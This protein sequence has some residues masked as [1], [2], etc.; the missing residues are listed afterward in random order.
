VATLQWYPKISVNE[1]QQQY[2]EQQIK[3]MRKRA[4]KYEYELVD[5]APAPLGQGGMATAYK[6]TTPAWIGA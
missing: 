3:Y 2:E 6:A 1:Y 4:A 5:F